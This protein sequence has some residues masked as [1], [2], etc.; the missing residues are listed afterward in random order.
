M[1]TYLSNFYKYKDLIIELIRKDIKLK[2]RNSFL[3][4]L[5]SI[6]N[7]LLFMLVL[8]IIFSELFSSSIE[9][10][11]IYVLTG[12]LLY[13]CF[14]ETTNFAMQSV[15]TN[16]TL[17]KKVYVPKYF[18]PIS[19]IFSSFINSLLSMFS[20]I[21]VMLFSGLPLDTTN[22][23]VVFPLF[24]LLLFCIGI[25][26]ILSTVYVFFRDIQHIYSL[27]L[28]IV[29]YAS[30]IFYPVDIIPER[31]MPII[32]M[33]PLFGIVEMFR[34]TL[35]YHTVPSIGA[36]LFSLIYSIVLILIGL[37]L[38]YRKQDKFIFYL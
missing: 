6:L 33:N 17:M 9:N 15:V 31:F 3:G 11:P 38:F 2:Y 29:M 36:H 30:A 19:R 37:F 12:R 23:L 28:V 10:F 13:S 32:Q 8:T 27:F 24:Y 35:I 16:A 5:W 7:P 18:F 22:L 25:G 1:R 34:D 26:L 4:L 20:I 21:P 14:S